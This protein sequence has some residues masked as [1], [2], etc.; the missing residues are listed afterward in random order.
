MIARR[1]R[2]Y[3]ITG[4]LV[5]LPM[6]VTIWV[7][8]W[9]YGLL[10]GIFLSVLGAANAVLPGLGHLADVW[11]GIPGFGVLIVAVVIVATGVFVANI[12]GQWWLRQWDKMMNRIPVVRNIYTSV[13]Q[14]SDTLFSGSGNAFSKALLIRYPHTEAW[15]M[16]FLTGRPGGEVAS[17]LDGEYVS[18]FIPTTPNPT[19]GFF[20]ML[21][22][23]HVIELDMTVDDALKYIISM[24]VVVPAGPANPALQAR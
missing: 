16:A 15:S 20:L 10:D 8:T 1:L 23:H 24:G 12:F 4:L 19:S 18:V 6:A 17:K 7:L 3:F 21:P 5:W 13:K 11:R 14:V 9:L 22:R 2:Q